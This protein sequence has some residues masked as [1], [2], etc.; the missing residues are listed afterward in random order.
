MTNKT[1]NYRLLDHTADLGI[2]VTA[3][4]QATLFEQAGH[5]LLHVMFGEASCNGKTETVNVSLSGNDAPDLMVR[6][7]SEI[8]YL[9]E[10]ERL[11]VADIKINSVTSTTINAALDVLPFDPLLHEIIREIKAVT[12]HQIK[13]IEESG[14]WTARVIF[15]L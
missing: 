12:Y 8:L 2:E 15:D 4:S 1:L 13:V 5:A 3:A 14:T 10:G 11:F 6:W 7:L 9:L